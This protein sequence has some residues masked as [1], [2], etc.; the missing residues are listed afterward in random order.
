[1][2][3]TYDQRNAAPS[4]PSARWPAR[5]TPAPERQPPTPAL[6]RD[7]NAEQ[8]P[9]EEGEGG[10]AQDD[11]SA[12]GRDEADREGQQDGGRARGEEQPEAGRQRRL[13]VK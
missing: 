11:V 6:G 1:M 7:Q 2:L 8:A 3:D 10:L 4:S 13:L 5:Y 12:H 9:E